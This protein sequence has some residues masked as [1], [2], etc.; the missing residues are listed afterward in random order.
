MSDHWASR[1]FPQLLPE[2][3]ERI[4]GFVN[5]NEVATSFRLV[6]KA[7]AAQLRGPEHTTIRLSQPVPAHTF[8]SHWLAPGAT[9][10]LTLKQRLKLVSLTAASGVVA[11]LE[12]AA[13][14]ADCTLPYHIFVDIAATGH[15]ES[16]KRVWEHGKRWSKP[17]DALA[18]AAG[19]GH[20]HV[21]EWLLSLDPSL[22]TWAVA[23][24]SAPAAARGGH[25]ALSEWL[26]QWFEARVPARADAS[27]R[28]S[29]TRVRGLVLL[30]LAH[31]CDLATLQRYWRRWADALQALRSAKERL[32]GAAAGSPTPDWAAKVEWLEAE[33]C[34]KC[35]DA[36]WNA[37]AASDAPARLTWL[38]D[39]GY[40][41]GP[42]AFHVAARAGNLE[43]MQ[44]LRPTHGT[45]GANGGNAGGE[46]GDN[47]YDELEEQALSALGAATMGRQDVLQALHDA[48]CALDLMHIKIHAARSTGQLPVL[49]WLLQEYGP[50]RLGLDEPL[51][52]SAAG[53][54]SVGL[55]AWLRER[56][57]AWHADAWEAAAGAGCVEALEWLAERGCPMPED[58]VERP[59]VLALLEEHAR[60]GGEGLPPAE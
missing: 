9:R 22:W 17:Y 40:A 4:V 21:C 25:A 53:S 60:G 3:A 19:G 47:E 34:P 43:A 48:G 45:V 10:G 36:A 1:V 57:C 27:D 52:T 12:V 15:L 38:R 35:E 6:C 26:L 31:C 54:G 39:R 51:F 8:A 49:A 16:C 42:L 11:N 7:T 56:G 28:R 46:A 13:Q 44:L 37:A 59:D 58:G 2:L 30:G 33:G 24:S 5:R 32:L 23:E 20:A 41:I 18:A 29:L 50:D 14:A 55:L